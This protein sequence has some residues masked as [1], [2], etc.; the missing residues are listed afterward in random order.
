MSLF[1]AVEAFQKTI[2]SLKQTPYEKSIADATSNVNWGTPNSQLIDLAKSAEDYSNF[3]ILMKAVWEGVGDKKEKWRR[4]FK[5]LTLLEYCVKYGPERCVED[6]RDGVHRL[7]QLQD[8]KF[9]E[10]GRDKGAGIREKSRYLIQMLG[11]NES[12]KQER[13]KAK[14]ASSGLQK[15]VGIGSN[16]GPKMLGPS[17]TQN[18]N[19]QAPTA[20]RGSLPL[21]SGA[22]TTNKLDEYRQKD[23]Q[24]SGTLPMSVGG[25]A[26]RMASTRGSNS[27][28]NA[29]Y[30]GASAM[31]SSAAQQGISSGSPAE[32][33]ASSIVPSGSKSPVRSK[34]PAVASG[35][36]TKAAAHSSFRQKSESE[37]ESEDSEEESEGSDL[38]DMGSSPVRGNRSGSV[39]ANGGQG[40]MGGQAGVG[41]QGYAQPAQ[42]ANYPQQNYPHQGSYAPPGFAQPSFTQPV[43]YSSPPMSYSAQPAFGRQGYAHQVPGFGQQVPGYGQQPAAFNQQAYSQQTYQQPN[44]YQSGPAYPNPA[45]PGAMYGQQYGGAQFGQPPAVP[46]AYSFNQPGFSQQGPQAAY[47]QP[48]Y[49]QNPAQSQNPTQTPYGQS[50][51]AK[52]NPSNNPFLM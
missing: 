7:R 45:S 19:I 32:R 3:L 21:H 12:I 50:Q 22:N 14:E 44:V 46:S 34:A 38:L 51:Q 2:K 30:T 1:G 42:P 35:Q 31:S 10:E 4:V 37:S 36:R 43:S 26:S 5:S 13:D 24:R 20:A 27:A 15:Y 9:M 6:A 48:G 47:P 39:T 8:F 16:D 18:V 40:S 25:E 49:P 52:T 23:L 17:T 11:S 33:A 41:G 29:G 28:V